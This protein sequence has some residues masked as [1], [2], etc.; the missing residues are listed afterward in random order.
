MLISHISLKE[1]QRGLHPRV[2]TGLGKQ[3]NAFTCV[4]KACSLWSERKQG[5]PGRDIL[6][7]SGWKISEM[8]ELGDSFSACLLTA[9]LA[10]MLL[11]YEVS[12]G[13]AQM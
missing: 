2:P 4:R 11:G 3:M 1:N 8:E 9:A 6:N 12:S 10:T 13:F 7:G 5:M